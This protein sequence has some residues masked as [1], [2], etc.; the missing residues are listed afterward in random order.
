MS[1]GFDSTRTLTVRVRSASRVTRDEYHGQ[2]LRPLFECFG[3]V[4]AVQ[5]AR[6]GISEITR[7]NASFAAAPSIR[8][9]A[10]S[11]VGA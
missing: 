1:N 4:D 7:S 2:F 9:N 10:S 6:H 11:A 8:R 5:A 3:E